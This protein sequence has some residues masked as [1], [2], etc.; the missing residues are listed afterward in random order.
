[1][2]KTELQ[3]H[4]PAPVRGV[5][6]SQHY[7]AEMAHFLTVFRVLSSKVRYTVLTRSCSP[8][9]LLTS[10]QKTVVGILSPGV[11]SVQCQSIWPAP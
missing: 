10:N 3:R 4:M 7:H 8:V 9:S 11:G 6:V 2:L 1:M 5:M